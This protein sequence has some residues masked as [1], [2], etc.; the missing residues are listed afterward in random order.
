MPTHRDWLLAASNA[1]TFATSRAATV[2]VMRAALLAAVLG[3]PLT[4]VAGPFTDKIMQPPKH[5]EPG[6]PVAFTQVSRTIYLNPCLPS[7][8][9]VYPGFDDSR[10]DHS[11][12]PNAQSVLTAY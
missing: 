6:A 4:A 1:Q 9:T 12:I 8:C 7:G 5:R 11:S 10:S 2:R 3:L